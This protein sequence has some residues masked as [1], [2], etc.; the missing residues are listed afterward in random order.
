MD[1]S[2]GRDWYLVAALVGLAIA[3]LL[4][5]VILAAFGWLG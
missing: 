5:F 1:P 3:P 2:G 4:A